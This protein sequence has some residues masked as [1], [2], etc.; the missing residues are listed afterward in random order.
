MV[1]Q[2]RCSGL[3]ADR[4]EKMNGAVFVAIAAA[5]GNLLQGWDNATIAGN[6]AESIMLYYYVNHVGE[7]KLKIA[8]LNQSQVASSLSLFCAC[9][10]STS[11]LLNLSS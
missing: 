1:S 6:S 3:L 10:Q 7:N 9:S 8:S 11:L 4:S 5:I 2:F